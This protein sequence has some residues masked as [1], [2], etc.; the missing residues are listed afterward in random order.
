MSLDPYDDKKLGGGEDNFTAAVEPGHQ[1]AYGE[2]PEVRGGLKRQLKSRHVSHLSK[3]TL[4][5]HSDGVDGHDL[6]RRSHRYRIV[7][8]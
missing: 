6:N 8:R 7:P 5:P 3:V 1:V 2:E 4:A